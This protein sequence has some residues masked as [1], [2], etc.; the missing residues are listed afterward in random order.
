M[1]NLLD[2]RDPLARFGALSVVFKA[3]AG[4]LRLVDWLHGYSGIRQTSTELLIIQND[5]SIW[6]YGNCALNFILK[7]KS[8]LKNGLREGEGEPSRC[9]FITLLHVIL[10]RHKLSIAS[11]G[12]RL[13]GQPCC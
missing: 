3:A 9:D 5:R 12:T 10:H 13:Y 2:M 6:L 8:L 11:S 1:S 7:H 4:F